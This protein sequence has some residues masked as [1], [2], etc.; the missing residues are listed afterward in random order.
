MEA[1]R[2]QEATLI[3]VTVPTR[4]KLRAVKEKLG[5]N[6]MM[7]TSGAQTPGTIWVLGSG[8]STISSQVQGAQTTRRSDRL[9]LGGLISLPCEMESVMRVRIC[10]KSKK[11]PT[12]VITIAWNS[13]EE[14]QSRR[15][16]FTGR[17]RKRLKTSFQSR[18]ARPIQET[19]GLSNKRSLVPSKNKSE[20]S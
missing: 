14:D 12:I 1:E 20:T 19:L 4:E 13:R 16:L 9:R 11:L 8:A 2:T 18:T 7:M 17:L 10:R 6:Q 5:K 3:L 15:G